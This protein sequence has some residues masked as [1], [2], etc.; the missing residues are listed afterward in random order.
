M[1]YM[2]ENY[3][4]QMRL[5]CLLPLQPSAYK[6]NANNLIP[7]A[8]RPGQ[9]TLVKDI[10]PGIGDGLQYYD[11]GSMMNGRTVFLVCFFF[12]FVFWPNPKFLTKTPFGVTDWLTD[13]ALSRLGYRWACLFNWWN[14]SRN[15]SCYN[16]NSDRWYSIWAVRISAT[17][18]LSFADFGF[19]FVIG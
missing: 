11:G 1:E 6:E 15:S 7:T 13:P 8:L 5:V 19:F 10:N 12:P 16:T 18:H 17:L 3:G 2:V 9:M 4:K 14:F